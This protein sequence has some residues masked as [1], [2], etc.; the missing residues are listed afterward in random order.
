MRTMLSVDTD[1]TPLEWI[2]GIAS[3]KD[4]KGMLEVRSRLRNP[5]SSDVEG[6]LCLTKGTLEEVIRTVHFAF[7]CVRGSD[8]SVITEGF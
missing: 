7:L 8:A 4:N 1:I 6:A 5:I 3:G 2:I